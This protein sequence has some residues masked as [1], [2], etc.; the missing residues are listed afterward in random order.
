M[1]ETFAK[2]ILDRY[3]KNKAWKRTKKVVIINESLGRDAIELLFQLQT[4][5]SHIF[6]FYKDKLLGLHHLYIPIICLKEIFDIAHRTGHLG[7]SKCFEL[8]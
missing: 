4:Q 2:K 6:L 8:I 1:S 3:N 5:F 7:F